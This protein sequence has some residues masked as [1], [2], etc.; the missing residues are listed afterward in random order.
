MNK[1][2]SRASSSSSP[3]FSSDQKREFHKMMKERLVIKE[4]GFKLPP[5]FYPQICNEIEKRGWKVL[6]KPGFGCETS[7]HEFYANARIDDK[8]KENPIDQPAYKSWFRNTEIDYS[9]AAIHQLLNLPESD[10]YQ[11]R[12]L[13]YQ[14]LMHPPIHDEISQAIAIPGATWQRNSTRLLKRHVTSDARIWSQFT[15]STVLP[16]SHTYSMNHSEALLLYCIIK[17]CPI[18]VSRIIADKISEVSN[19]N[20]QDSRLPYPWLITKLVQSQKSGYSIKMPIM[21]EPILDSK[22]V[23]RVTETAAKD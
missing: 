17:Q 13:S 7:V 15:M 20:K 18:D 9:V 5:Q 22:E 6:V 2:K 19:S 16:V 14:E 4:R 3:S 12:L 23:H 11:G 21:P 8:E 10:P 1:R